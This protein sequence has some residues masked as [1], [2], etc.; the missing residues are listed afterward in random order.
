MKIELILVFIIISTMLQLCKY[1]I[2]IN[3]DDK[4]KSTI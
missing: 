1:P 2:I 3:N 4:K